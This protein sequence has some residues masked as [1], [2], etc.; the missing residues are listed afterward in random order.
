MFNRFWKQ[1][2]LPTLT[3]L[4]LTTPRSLTSHIWL[5]GGSG[6]GKS[7][8]L[9]LIMHDVLDMG[10]SCMWFG[11]K[12][13][14]ADAAVRIISE[15]HQR[16][17]LI[18][19]VPGKFTFNV[20]AYE[21]G[22]KGGSPATLMRLIERLSEMVSRT[23]GGGDSAAFWKGLFN[24]AIE[25]AATLGSLAYKEKVTLENIYDIAMT[26][27]ASLSQIQAETFRESP[28]FQLLQRAEAGIKT[29]GDRQAYKQAV[30]F[31]LQRVPTIGE[32]ARGAM[33]T[34]VANVLAP[35][36]RSP[37]YETLCSPSSSFDPEMPLDG[38]C[39]VIDFPVLVW[40]DAALL[41]QNLL[42][43]LT[44]EAALRR[45]NRE[46]ITAFVKDEYQM[47]CA[48]PEFD[49][50]A[51]SVARSHGIACLA[52][53]QSVPLLRVAMGGDGPGEQRAL[54]LLGN[55]NTQL[56]LANQCTETNRFF[57]ESWGQHREDFVSVSENKQEEELDLLNMLL[58]NDRLLFSVGQQLAPR[59]SPA[60]FLD[61][62]RGGP[63]NKF[64]V[65]AFL[66]QG[67]R[68]FGPDNSPFTKVSFK[69]RRRKA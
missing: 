28:F 1:Q 14:E 15:S 16:D 23:D 36:L 21:L 17:R 18:R 54:G 61:L 42:S 26:C 66:T 62:R 13:D 50:M 6:S 2:H 55:F 31:F 24:G 59:C 8:L 41:L 19:L 12:S 56:T 22:R 57:S 4:G 11:V 7:S 3:K 37:F 58:G 67:G 29:P 53:T 32:K 44:M 63:E 25:F 43:M 48:S 5:T 33:T 30:A 20:A 9:E 47:L 65:D 35:L 46:Q 38:C 39:V 10:V 45:P 69:Q 27:P 49:C 64:I 60:A 51:L 34:S 40:G 52:A 68:T